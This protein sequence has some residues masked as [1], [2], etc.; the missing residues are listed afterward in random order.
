VALVY[1]KSVLLTSQFRQAKDFE[2]VLEEQ[3]LRVNDIVLLNLD[4]VK[5]LLIREQLDTDNQPHKQSSEHQ[6]QKTSLKQAKAY[7][8]ASFPELKWA[9]SALGVIASFYQAVGNSV[10]CEKV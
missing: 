10:K 1:L 5:R 6:S 2:R 7:K 9:L 8:Q 3:L 4:P